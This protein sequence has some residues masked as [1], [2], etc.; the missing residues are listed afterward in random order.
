MADDPDTPFVDEEGFAPASD[1]PLWGT[2]TKAN[3]ETAILT[4][5]D[6]ACL[7]DVQ[8]HRTLRL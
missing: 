2:R 7:L 1:P 5:R 3:G 6:E 8:A 4:Y